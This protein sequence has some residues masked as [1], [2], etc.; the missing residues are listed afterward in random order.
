MCERK[1][2]ENGLSYTHFANGCKSPRTCNVEQC[3]I[4]RK[5]LGSLHDA[6]L[7]SFRR[8]QGEN[9]NPETSVS[10]SSSVIQTQCGH[11]TMKSSISVAGGSHECKAVLFVPVKVKK[12]GRDESNGLTS[13]WC[14]EGLAKRLSAIGPRIQVSLST[15]EKDSNFTSCFRIT[16][17]V[18]HMTRLNVVEL[19][20]GSDKKEVEHFYG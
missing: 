18:M 8:R 1:L 14:S 9:R 10:P 11:I 5:N 3:T 7:T 20:E 12:R 2:C 16:L 19:P 17:E 4:T 13:T 6:L 15:I